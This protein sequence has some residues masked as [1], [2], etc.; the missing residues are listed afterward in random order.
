MCI[1]RPDEDNSAVSFPPHIKSAMRQIWANQK[2]GGKDGSARAALSSH[3]LPIQVAGGGACLLRTGAS[4]RCAAGD[5]GDTVVE[6]G[7]GVAK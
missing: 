3:P 7:S 1:V 4:E 2:V 5:A 6:A